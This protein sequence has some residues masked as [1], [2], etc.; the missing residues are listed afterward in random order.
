MSDFEDVTLYVEL[1]VGLAASAALES[2]SAAVVG[3]EVAAEAEKLAMAETA[4]AV[5]AACWRR[6][7]R[8]VLSSMSL[9]L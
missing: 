7:G 8:L 2:V 3:T 5:Y 9:L 6:H 4:E 1:L